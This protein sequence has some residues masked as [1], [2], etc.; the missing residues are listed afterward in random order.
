MAA[1]PNIE[2]YRS[3]RDRNKSTFV[4]SQKLTELP[5]SCSNRCWVFRTVFFPTVDTRSSSSNRWRLPASSTAVEVFSSWVEILG[6]HGRGAATANQGFFSGDLFSSFIFLGATIAIHSMIFAFAGV[7]LY[8]FIKDG[9]KFKRLLESQKLLFVLWTNSIK[10]YPSY[11]Q[12][13]PTFNHSDNLY[14]RSY[15]S[16]HPSIH[17]SIYL[18]IDLSIY[19]PIDL[20][21]CLSVCLAVYLSICLFVYLSIYLIY[22]NL[23]YSNLLYSNLL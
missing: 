15:L 22:S 7:W 9:P 2:R 3:Y 1:S 12:L 4:V 5:H 19:R 8:D 10:H 20:S 18:S 16:I 6:R 11:I 23:I 17:P 21:I 13:T 14:I